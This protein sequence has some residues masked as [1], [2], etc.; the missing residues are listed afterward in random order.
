MAKKTKK[1][2]AERRAAKSAE[3]CDQACRLAPEDVRS[4]SGHRR[5]C[6]ADIRDR[7]DGLELEALKKGDAP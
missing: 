2:A 1:L 5:A 4:E 3:R 6:P 7:E